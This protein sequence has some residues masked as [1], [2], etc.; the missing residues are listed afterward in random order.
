MTMMGGRSPSRGNRP[1]LM[2]VVLGMNLVGSCPA[3]RMVRK[4]LFTIREYML[5]KHK[6]Q[7]RYFRGLT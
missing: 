2:Y 7:G 6:V 5:V 1:S 3:L 4:N